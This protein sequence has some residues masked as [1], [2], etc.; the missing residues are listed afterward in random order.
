[1]DFI[2]TSFFEFSN[3]S[4]IYSEIFCKMENLLCEYITF[5]GVTVYQFSTKI[6]M[7][8][9]RKDFFHF[10][11]KV[12][13]RIWVIG[14]LRA[15]IFISYGFFAYSRNS[16]YFPRPIML[17]SPKSPNSNYFV[18]P[19]L[20][21]RQKLQRTQIFPIWKRNGP[22]L[23]QSFNNTPEGLDK[24]F[25]TSIFLYGNNSELFIYVIIMT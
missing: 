5:G 13:Y 7:Y 19:P 2:L 20:V 11:V 23:Y 9:F 3:K 16:A 1:M 25:S 12:S 8:S 4:Y 22:Y 21:S 17:E 6:Y 24:A 10:C 18:I 14:F 15:W